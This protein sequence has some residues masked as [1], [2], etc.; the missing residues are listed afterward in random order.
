MESTS[1]RK[2]SIF[3]SIRAFSSAEIFV[4]FF[5]GLF[6]F[7]TRAGFTIFKKGFHSFSQYT[8]LNYK[9]EHL[10]NASVDRKRLKFY[11]DLTL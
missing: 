1:D 4:E 11:D 10:I 8:E 2:A 9:H 5:F 7:G 6:C 3:S